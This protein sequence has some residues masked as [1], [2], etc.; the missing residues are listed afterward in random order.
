MDDP[1]DY[2]DDAVSL[3]PDD[4]G[5]VFFVGIVFGFALGALLVGLIWWLL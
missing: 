5:Y 4:E 1:Y 3:F 2:E